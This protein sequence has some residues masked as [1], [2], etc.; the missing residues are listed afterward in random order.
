MS[1]TTGMSGLVTGINSAAATTPDS[2]ASRLDSFRRYAPIQYEASKVLTDQQKAERRAEVFTDTALGLQTTPSNTNLYE[3]HYQLVKDKANL[4]FSDEVISH[5]AKDKRSQVEWAQKV[6]ALNQ[7]IAAYEAYYEDSIGDP[8]K[9]NGLGN[10][11]A[12]HTLRAKHQGGEQGFWSDQGVEADRTSELNEVMKAVDSRQH[13]S[14]KFNYETGEFEYDK[15]QSDV[16]VFNVNPQTANELFSYNLTQTSYATPSDYATDPKLAKVT[17][18]RTQFDQRLQT[19]M[20][21]DSFRRAVAHHYISANPDAGLTID[22]VMNDEVRFQD[23]Y[24][25]F[26]DQTY[27]FMESNARQSR[28][29]SGGGGRS[30]TPKPSF[31][32]VF[33]TDLYPGVVNTQA[34][35]KLTVTAI[36]PDTGLPQTGTV[37]IQNLGVN[38]DGAFVAIDGRGNEIPVDDNIYAQI[39]KVIGEDELARIRFELGNVQPSDTPSNTSPDGGD[40]QGE[41]SWFKRMKGSLGNTRSA[42]LDP[43]K[44]GAAGAALTMADELIWLYNQAGKTEDAEDYR[45][46]YNDNYTFEEF[47]FGDNIRIIDN[48]NPDRILEIGQ[49]ESDPKKRQGI[50]NAIFRFM[51]PQIYD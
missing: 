4:L 30:S 47:G 19:E 5:Y 28:R 20:G 10:T 41:Q 40:A 14:M 27:E 13:G 26:A 16:D 3:S 22:D 42:N 12:D 31:G 17:G 21:K 44:A 33:N 43:S 29:S 48:N 38:E 49:D 39:Q 9:A 46:R 11:W 2:V 25:D 1:K 23:A 37:K 15:L 24:E 51:N 8:S 50:A 7:E 45:D 34:P 6:D 36:N 32:D 35:L 18:D